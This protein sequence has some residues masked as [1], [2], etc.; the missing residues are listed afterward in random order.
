ME[1]FLAETFLGQDPTQPFP[2]DVLPEQVTSLGTPGAVKRRTN[3]GLVQIRAITA[4]GWSW[5]EQFGLLRVTEFEHMELMAFVKKAWHSGET[6]KIRHPIQ[7]GSGILP[8]GLGTANVMVVGAGQTGNSVLTD[9]WPADT[10]NC[11]V[12]GDVISIAGEV[13][14]YMVTATADSDGAGEVTISVNPPLRSSP[15]NTAIVK[16]TDVDFIGTIMGR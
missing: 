4:I 15:A 3:S 13:A 8:N 7:P 10:E 1:E 2:R 11:V 12:V 6:F 9:G 16:T 14:V 5:K